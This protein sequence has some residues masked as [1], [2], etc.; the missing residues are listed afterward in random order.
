M[1][2]P[3]TD[4]IREESERLVLQNSALH[5]NSQ[6]TSLAGLQ[7]PPPEFG[8]LRLLQGHVRIVA[9][10]ATFNCRMHCPF[11][12]SSSEALQRWAG[13]GRSVTKLVCHSVSPSR[14]FSRRPPTSRMH[15]KASP[16]CCVFRF[17]QPVT[18]VV[19]N[20]EWLMSLWW[21]KLN[22]ERRVTH[23]NMQLPFSL[24]QKL[25]G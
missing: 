12:S 13:S 22:N 23:L 10:A 16:H 18:S 11:T 17:A 3:L 14:A 6:S 5:V 24:T 20:T 7:T 2:C 4:L 9:C 19:V 8:I 25:I 15:M 1:T 21:H